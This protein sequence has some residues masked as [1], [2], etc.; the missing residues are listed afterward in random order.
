MVFRYLRLSS[1]SL[2]RSHLVPVLSFSVIDLPAFSPLLHVLRPILRF[3][4]YVLSGQS[5]LLNLVSHPFRQTPCL[6]VESSVVFV[7]QKSMYF[8]EI[9]GKRETHSPAL[10]PSMLWSAPGCQAREAM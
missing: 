3:V 4:P 5:D 6:L 9:A 8:G 1:T 7:Q 2:H 10:R